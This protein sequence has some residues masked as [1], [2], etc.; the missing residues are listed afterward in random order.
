MVR[1]GVAGRVEQF[2][3]RVGDVVNPMMRPA[4][5]LVPGLR[6]RSLVAGFGQVE[7]QVI[8]VGRPAEAT[9]ASQPWVIIPMV[10]TQVQGFIASGQLRSSDQLI[11][12]QNLRP[13]GTVLVVLE[14]LYEGGLDG[15]LPG[16]S[17][18]ANAHAASHDLIADPKIG[19]LRALGLHAVDAVGL[20]HAILLRMRS[21]LLPFKALVFS[22]GH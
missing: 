15:V 19:T 18:I 10:V 13:G 2:L 7:A 5:V 1:A 8:R 12:V 17:C 20:V 3:L 21:P 16:S 14:P 4:G 6:A 11:D 9:W 22:G